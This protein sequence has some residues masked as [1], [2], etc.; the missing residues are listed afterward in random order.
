MRILQSTA[1]RLW[2]LFLLL[3]ACGSGFAQPHSHDASWRLDDSSALA[4]VWEYRWGDSPFE[5]GKPIWSLGSDESAWRS[6][7]FPSDPPG[8]EGQ[9][10]AW[11]RVRLPKNEP[12][13]SL[14]IYSIDLIA[15]VYFEGAKI[16]Q[17]GSFDEAGHGVF[18]GWPWHLI[19]LPEDYGGKYLYFRIYSDYPDI[20]LWGEVA[21]GSEFGHI[22]RIIQRDLFPVA[23][24]M[25]ALFCGLLLVLSIPLHRQVPLLTMGIFLMLL[26]FIPIF[27]SQI[28]QLVVFAPVTLQYLAALNYFLLP[29]GM[30]ALV[31][32]LFGR[33]LWGIHQW[34]WIVHLAF[35][36]CA[37]V[38]SALGTINLSSCYIYFDALALVTMLV[39]SITLTLEARSQRGGYELISIGFWLLYIVMTYNG[40]TAHGILPFAP[41]SEY[42]GPLLLGVCFALILIRRYTHLSQ[43]LET[44]TLELETV[45]DNLKHT[46]AVRT[47]ELQ[48]TNQSNNQLLTI[49]GHDLKAPIGTL[50]E[51][52]R[53]Y[54]KDRTGI[55]ATEIADL[56]ES[57]GRVHRLLQDLLTWARGQQG[58]LVPRKEILDTQTLTLSA[59][60]SLSA[61]ATAK[62]I[63]LEVAPDSRYTIKADREMIATTI[64]NIVSNALKF[65][66]RGGAVRVAFTQ[67]A[68]EV[69]FTCED[70]GSGLKNEQ[71][72]K[73]F[74]PKS[75]QHLG[76]GTNG[77]EGSG[78]GMLLCQTFINTHEGKIGAENRESGGLRVWFTLPRV[79]GATDKGLW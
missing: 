10:N 67:Q 1:H 33:G 4:A 2:P 26:G 12:G 63:L 22:Q 19:D 7:A 35:A 54:E 55:P 68:D 23:I 3:F 57:C 52:L 37:L 20:G 53:E 48:A 11:F 49:I 51:L 34:I 47:H 24:G 74:R 73:L 15:E 70:N 42:I 13:D 6:I 45:N 28:K 17:Y 72:D 43:S 36:A 30:A 65:T 79:D 71:L 60:A 25:A 40:L 76:I 77:E 66:P 41:R 62:H 39:L 16:Y 56:R 8:R 78:L 9:T 31:H 69:R 38:L 61:M 14:Y 44:R 59:I 75:E 21:I 50:Y 46:V 64:R 27:E 58:E 32:A 18:E 29:V 5:A